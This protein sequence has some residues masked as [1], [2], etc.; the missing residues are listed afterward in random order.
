[1]KKAEE[2]LVL[3]VEDDMQSREFMVTLMKKLGFQ[4]LEAD[5]GVTALEK[6]KSATPDLFLVDGM[7]PTMDGFELIGR[8]REM[9]QF[10]DTPII[11]TTALDDAKNIKESIAKGANAYV[12]KPIN[13]LRL[14]GKIQ[15]LM[16]YES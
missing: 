14:K 6:L 11:M 7:M 1:M 15:E 12:V 9:S 13:V 5:S 2:C 8:I 3:I 10:A 4:Y 16:P